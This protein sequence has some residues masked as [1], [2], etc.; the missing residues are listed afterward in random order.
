MKI[1]DND[2]EIIAQNKILQLPT[3]LHISKHFYRFTL[4]ISTK[5]KKKQIRRKLVCK[6]IS[7]CIIHFLQNFKFW[8]QFINFLK[9]KYLTLRNKLETLK[10]FYFNRCNVNI[11]TLKEML[12]QS[13]A[14]KIYLVKVEK[15]LTKMST[16]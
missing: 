3:Y 12:T 8:S 15:Y 2:L 5:L 13:G 10:I 6:I 9:K 16:N 4:F 1:K 11:N 7:L 14:L